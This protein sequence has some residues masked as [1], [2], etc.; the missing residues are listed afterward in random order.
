MGP[1]ALEEKANGQDPLPPNSGADHLALLLDF[2]T[3]P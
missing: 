1:D 3:Q 2:V